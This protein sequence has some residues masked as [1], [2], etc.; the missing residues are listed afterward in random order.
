MLIHV[1]FHHVFV[2]HLNNQAGLGLGNSLF[3]GGILRLAAPEPKRIALI[4]AHLARY[5]Y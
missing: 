5:L 2:T 1:V 4:S 3:G